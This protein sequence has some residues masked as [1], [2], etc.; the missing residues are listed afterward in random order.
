M[1]V[2]PIHME[3]L[4]INHTQIGLVM[5]SSAIATMLFRPLA[6]KI[7]D[8]MGFRKVLLFILALFP[9]VLLGFFLPYLTSFGMVQIL[10]GVIAAF[11]S[12]A[13]GILTIQIFSAKTRGQGLSLNALASILPSTFGPA[14]ALYLIEFINIEKIFIGFL[15]LGVV[16]FFTLK[17]LPVA[18]KK[19]EIQPIQKT[20]VNA[21]SLNVPVFIGA[22][23]AILL[24]SISNGAIF[25]FLPLYFK[26]INNPNI[27]IYFLTQTTVLVGTRFIYSKFI[28]NQSRRHASI[29]LLLSAFCAVATLIISLAENPAWFILAAILN[30]LAFSSLYPILVT[31][32]SFSISS[33]SLGF[34]L[35]IFIGF[36]DLGVALGSLMMGFVCENSS[37]TTMYQLCACLS[38]LGGGTFFLIMTHKNIKMTEAPPNLGKSQE[39][40]IWGGA[41]F[42]GARG[43]TRTGTEV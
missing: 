28:D 25:T 34:W 5:G 29:I 30:G 6:G 35:S 4:G 37:F 32:V 11:F 7:T 14:I 9:F 26:E 19:H 1:V 21:S 10:T 36:A 16:N 22:S 12:T 15:V 31:L 18:G 8:K 23:L 20:S 24:T 43:R 41:E 17:S 27:S 2:L 39:P 3:K 42:S 13:M 33:K 40:R 38:L